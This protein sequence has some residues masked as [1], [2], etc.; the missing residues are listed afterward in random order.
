MPRPPSLSSFAV[1]A[2]STLVTTTQNLD[3][4]LLECPAIPPPI[5]NAS[6]PSPHTP[7]PHDERQGDC[8]IPTMS[9]TAGATEAVQREEKLVA[10]FY[11][12][13]VSG[14]HYAALGFYA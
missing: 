6:E 2:S 14:V 11:V 13:Y 3:A 12:F 9:T 8:N 10:S 1:A 4:N 5:T 7:H